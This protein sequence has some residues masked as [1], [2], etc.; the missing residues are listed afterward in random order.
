MQ[1]ASLHIIAT[2]RSKMEYLRT[3]DDQ[4]KTEIKKVGLAPIQ[5]QGMEYEFDILAEM[6]H[7]HRCVIGDTRCPAV[8]GISQMKPDGAWFQPILDWLDGAEVPEK[9]APHWI[10]GE[11]VRKRFWAWTTSMALDSAEVH[12]ALDVKHVREYAGFMREA[13]DQIIAY[14]NRKAAETPSEEERDA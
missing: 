2:M 12:E 14:I 5:R 13:K 9:I 7:D 11:E 8:D 10:D 6:R 1:G 4:G 3:T